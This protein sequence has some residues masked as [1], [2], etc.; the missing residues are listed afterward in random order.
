M[1]KYFR[2]FFMLFLLVFFLIFFGYF[3]AGWYAY[4]MGVSMKPTQAVTPETVRYFSQNDTTQREAG[5]WPG[6]LA[7]VLAPA[8]D[9]AGLQLSPLRVHHKLDSASL[10]KADGDIDWKSISKAFPQVSFYHKRI[11]TSSAVMESLEQHHLPL[12]KIKEAGTEN[13][14]WLLVTGSD[15]EDFLVVD[16]QLNNSTPQHLGKYG[17]VFAYRVIFKNIAGE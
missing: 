9:G 16:P 2:L 8:L 13:F 17:K 4:S 10:Y 15:K 11:L 5:T 3:A 14:R 12:V 6:G 1:K 7:L